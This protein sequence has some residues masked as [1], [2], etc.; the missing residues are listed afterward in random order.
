MRRTV[1]TVITG[2]FITRN[3]YNE[4]LTLAKLEYGS[5]LDLC[6]PICGKILRILNTTVKT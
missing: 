3:L 2:L 4:F 5:I 6:F 1:L